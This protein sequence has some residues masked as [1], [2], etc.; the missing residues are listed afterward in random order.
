M[1]LPIPEAKKAVAAWRAYGEASQASDEE[2]LKNHMPLVR[3]VVDRLRASLPAHLDVDD[4]YSVGL[5]GLI[6]A[7]RRFDPTL[8]VTFSSYAAVRI[9]GAVLDELRRVDWMSRTLRIKAKKLSDVIAAFEQKVGRPATEAEIANELGITGEEYSVLLDEV[10]P[11]SYVEL[12]ALAGDD[13]DSSLH[14]VIADENQPNA[15]ELALKNE[16]IQ[17]VVERLQKLPDMQR[18]ILAMYYFENL[19]L[20]EIARVFGITESRVCQI[21]TQAVLG[22]KAYIRKAMDR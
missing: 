7:Q 17:I 13:E 9:R 11:L 16:L 1:S 19:R 12:D 18:K 15:R 3:S 20:A 21:H 6:Q 4:L 22:L 14:E 10:R 5:L 2:I 8:G